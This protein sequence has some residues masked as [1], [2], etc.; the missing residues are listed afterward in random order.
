MVGVFVEGGTS[1]SSKSLRVQHMKENTD[2]SNPK[3]PPKQKNKTEA[4]HPFYYYAALEHLSAT[5]VW[6]P[7][8]TA[9]YSSHCRR[10]QG[11][12]VMTPT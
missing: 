6:R 5:T 4:T 12:E 9:G 1:F 8:P 7:G 11:T 10:D 3:K 2:H